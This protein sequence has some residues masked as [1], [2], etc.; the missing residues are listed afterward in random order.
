MFFKTGF[1]KN[2]PVNIKFLRTA[3]LKPYFSNGSH[4]ADMF[5]KICQYY[6]N[7]FFKKQ[8]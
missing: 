8:L 1:L 6:Q 4:T 3:F 7:R 2:F 5:L